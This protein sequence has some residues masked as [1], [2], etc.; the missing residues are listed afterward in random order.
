MIAFLSLH[1]VVMKVRL[2]LPGD[3]HVACDSAALADK[4]LQSE[5]K[6]RGTGFLRIKSNSEI[7]NASAALHGRYGNAFA[8]DGGC[9]IAAELIL[10]SKAC[11]YGGLFIDFM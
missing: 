3:L 2:K 11:S 9:C 8:I 4:T 6:N 7:K 5:A 10:I 1:L